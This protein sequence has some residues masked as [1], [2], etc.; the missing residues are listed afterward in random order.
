MLAANKHFARAYFLAVASIEETGK[1]ILLFNARGRNIH[2]PAVFSRL[3]KSW[4]DHD[5][6]ITA[7]F[8][9]WL[10]NDP[11]AARRNLTKSF[12]LMAALRSGREPAMYSDIRSDN[13]QP[14]LPSEVVRPSAA[15][16]CVRLAIDCLASARHHLKTRTP[17]QYSQDEDR[18]FALPRTRYLRIL[19]EKDFWWFYLAEMKAGRGDFAAAVMSYREQFELTKKQFR[20]GEGP[21]A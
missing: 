20:T 9:P 4:S 3:I 16:D 21:D 6:K 2:D 18:L 7:A 1:A 8:V 15:L 14:Q 19:N 13:H 5:D 17:A 11:E 12:E 10:V